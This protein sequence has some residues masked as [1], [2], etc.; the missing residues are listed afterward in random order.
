MSFPIGLILTWLGIAALW[1]A[2][3]GT[4]ATTPWGVWEQ[5]MGQ[6][7]AASTTEGNGAA[8][9][10]TSGGSAG[11]SNAALGA[12]TGQQAGSQVPGP[13]GGLAGEL[14]GAIGGALG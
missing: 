3:H 7:Q 9:A 11:S 13:F 4:N 6:G 10:Q 12:Q 14:G 1:V 2:F 8:G 5:I